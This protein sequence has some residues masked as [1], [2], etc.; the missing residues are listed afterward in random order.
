M[1]SSWLIDQGT[2][3]PEAGGKIHSSFKEAFFSVEI[4][5]VGDYVEYGTEE[6]IRRHKRMLSKGKDYVMQPGD[7]A[8]YI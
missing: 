1:V 3:A 5:K 2:K 6:N 7:V 4:C 8:I